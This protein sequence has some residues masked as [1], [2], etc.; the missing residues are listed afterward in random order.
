MGKRPEV[1]WLG[2]GAG[3]QAG[4]SNREGGRRPETTS[5]Q[6]S[7]IFHVVQRAISTGSSSLSD[8]RSGSPA[9]HNVILGRTVSDVALQNLLLFA[10]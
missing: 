3:K 4:R 8:G 1:V 9:E 2:L 5:L 10:R 6:E 7:A